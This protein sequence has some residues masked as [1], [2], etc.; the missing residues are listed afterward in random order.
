M[1]R[2]GNFPISNLLLLSS[3]TSSFSDTQKLKKTRK[4]SQK[5]RKEK[6]KA[7]R[8]LLTITEFGNDEQRISLK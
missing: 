2:K 3:L 6:K 5:K 8:K 7:E 1:N 4:A